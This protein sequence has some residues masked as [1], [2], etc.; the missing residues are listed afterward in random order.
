MKFGIGAPTCREGV[1]YP[2]PFAD[3]KDI[4]EITLLAENL[5]LDS[6]WSTDWITPT[7][8]RKIPDKQAPNW[9][10]LLISMAYCSAVTS[11]ITLATG[12]V[13]L[14]FRDTVIL[15]KQIATLDQ[16]CNGRLI[17]GVGLG[18]N[19]EE[20]EF[21]RARDKNTHRGKLFDEQIAA[22]N[23]LLRHDDVSFSGEYVEFNNLSLNP[24][25]TNPIPVYF[26]GNGVS[27]FERVAKWGTG[28]L[29]P[30]A[31]YRIA[32][33][34]ES[35]KI[36]LDK[37]GRDISEIDVVGH[38]YTSIA[39]TNEQAIKMFKESRLG[40]RYNGKDIGKVLDENLIGTPVEIAAHINELAGEGMTHCIATSFAVDT[41]EE[42]KE[43]VQMFVEEVI[44]FC[45]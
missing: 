35:L 22:L 24:K 10:D 18:G 15:A 33:K 16:F 3:T 2:V 28:L 14:P 29:I 12:T 1:F 38:T 39:K 23:L 5:G 27:L 43:Q 6:I 45:R 4:V 32:A 40:R 17:L 9:Y 19:R 41:F 7:P 34:I 25:P 11:R 8:K 36:E 31:K 42:L 26:S 20:F 30:V 13:V 37:V 21:I 44:P